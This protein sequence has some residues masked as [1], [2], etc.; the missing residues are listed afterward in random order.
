MA[1]KQL[2]QN[3]LIELINL[4]AGTQQRQLSSEV[5]SHYQDLRKDGIELPPVELISTGNDYILWDGFHRLAVARN[6]G[7]THIRA[8]LE[9]GSPRH[10]VFMSL[11][12]NGAHGFPRHKGATQFVVDKMLQDSEWCKMRLADIARHVGCSRQYVHERKNLITGP[13]SRQLLDNSLT[14]SN[15]PGKEAQATSGTGGK[16]ETE[17]GSPLHDDEGQ[18][19]PPA[20]AD[21]FLSQSVIKDRINEL[22]QIKNAV[23]NRIAEGDLAYALLNQTGFQ[24]DMMNLRAR[25]SSAI[26]Y[27]ICPYCKGECCGACHN[28]GFLNEDSWKAAPKNSE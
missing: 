2:N 17:P 8:N 14:S 22:D 11:G 9:I 3:I 10:A 23:M 18:I 26:P 15:S 12:A 27:A 1:K 6:L 13:E 4:S 21:R 19:V 20:L 16:T 24:A 7:E 25:L 5:V 28:M